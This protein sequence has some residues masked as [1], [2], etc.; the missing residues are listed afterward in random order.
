[1][2]IQEVKDETALPFERVNTTRNHWD[3]IRHKIDPTILID[4]ASGQCYSRRDGARWEWPA[5]RVD[6]NRDGEWEPI[7]SQPAHY[8]SVRYEPSAKKSAA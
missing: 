4:C 8:D 6:R 3:W 7:H 1:M 5:Y 2:A